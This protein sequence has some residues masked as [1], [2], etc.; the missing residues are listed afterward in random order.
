MTETPEF[1]PVGDVTVTDHIWIP[2]PDGVRLAARLWLPDQVA[3]DPVPAIVE[4]IPYRKADMVRARDERNHPY[5]AA[6][7]YAC[8]RV[9][10]RG[11]GDSEGRMKDMY[12]DHEL[13]DTRH[14]IEWIAAQ[15][16]CDGKV[17]MFGT[18]WGGTASLQANMDAPEPLKAVIAVCATHDRFEDD[19]H[20]MGGCLQT[21]TFEWGATLPAILGAPPTPHAGSDWKMLW[22]ARLEDMTF[23]VEAWVREEARGAYWRHGSVI[24]EA[25]R[26]SR[27]VLAVGGWSDRYSNSVMSLVSA[28]PDLVWGIVGPWGHHYPDHGHPGP[29]IGFQ[30]LALAWWDRWLKSVSGALDWP[31]LRAWLRE[32]DP[33]ADAIDRRNGKWIETGPSETYTIPEPWR[34][35]EELRAPSGGN[36]DGGWPVPQ[37]LRVGRASG[38]TGYFGRHGGLPLDQRGDD[39]LALTF[40]TVPLDQDVVI[41]GAASARLRLRL[42]SSQ[43][44]LSIRLNDVAPDGTSARV[45]FCVRNLGLDDRLDAPAD[46]IP[47]DA[48]ELEIPFPATA[49]RFRKGHRIRLSFA[50][51]YWPL[52]W[53]SPGD[54]DVQIE[55]GA[56]L[57]PVFSREPDDL[58]QAFPP[59]LDLPMHKTH[60]ILES[61]QLR[62]FETEEIDGE[63]VGGW[64]QP[65]TEL[66]YNET[67][68]AFGFQTRAEYRIRPDDPTS[69]TASFIHAARYGRPDGVADIRCELIARCDATTFFLRATL[70][71]TWDGEQVAERL[72]ETSI[73]RVFG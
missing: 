54:G 19:I 23:P 65:F 31:R 35:G 70:T 18:S 64:D 17:G 13:A 56:L 49:Y 44:Q 45:G 1:D 73:P 72:W 12:G 55:S 61:P 51:S 68:T 40:E 37:D 71:A 36:V 24:H 57:L 6:H 10:M 41:Y 52:V 69:A 43:C 53:P 4:I 58:Q 3:P 60:R 9:D 67:D 47:L 14:V 11:S 46:P 29:A 16:W 63:L 7:G 30:Q 26:L 48:R 34:L 42:D 15:P 59:A 2:M 38:D 5:F 27:P 25:E 20:Y 8:L 22:K 39:A 32:F 21:D 62:R 33:P 28:R 50:R 66:H